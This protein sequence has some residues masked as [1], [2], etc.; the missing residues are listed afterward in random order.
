MTTLKNKV[1]IISGAGS[2]IGK[3]TALMMASNGAKVV[4]LGRTLAKIERVR[5]EIESREEA[6]LSF[7]LDVSD[8][9]GVHDMA[10]EVMNHF[11]QIDVLVNN[12][13]INSQHRRLLSITPEDM[14][15]VIDINLLGTMYCTQATV[16][17]ML[18]AKSGTIINISSLASQFPSPFSGVAYGPSKAAVNNFTEYL[19][20]EFKNTGI[21]AS[22]IIPGEVATP[23]LD[24]R[25]VPPSAQAR[26]KMVNVAETA[27]A[28]CLVASLPPR[29]NIPQLI[30]RPTWQRDMS[31]EI[32]PMT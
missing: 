28:I 15:H 6:C 30:I 29:T 7:K 17:F 14:R 10:Q 19:N 22:V 5:E 12:A 8:H 9:S 21:R 20:A 3:A 11:G 18:K 2:G 25:Y 27:E 13:G 24:Q 1:C 4:L 32:E 26:E 16:P 23:I 31:A